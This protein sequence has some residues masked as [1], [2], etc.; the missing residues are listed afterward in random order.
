MGVLA[1]V[2]SAGEVTVSDAVHVDPESLS[3]DGLAGAYRLAALAR[4]GA[5]RVDRQT[6]PVPHELDPDPD[7]ARSKIDLPTISPVIIEVSE[8]VAS[9]LIAEVHH[10]NEAYCDRLREAVRLGRGLT[11]AE[12]ERAINTTLRRIESPFY[13]AEMTAAVA[14]RLLLPDVVAPGKEKSVGFFRNLPPDFLHSGAPEDCYVRLQT[15]LRFFIVHDKGLTNARAVEECGVITATRVFPAGLRS[16]TVRDLSSLEMIEIA[17]PGITFG[18]DPPVRPWLRQAGEKWQGH[19]GRLLT[20]WG[21]AWTVRHGMKVFDPT[22]GKL[23][24]PKIKLLGLA[25]AIHS[26]GM[27]GAVDTAETTKSYGDVIRVGCKVLAGRDVVGLGHDQVRPWQLTSQGMW[28]R[29]GTDGSRLID[30][31][32]TFL[33]DY[34][35]PKKHPGTR[36]DDG[37]LSPRGLA[38]VP[39]LQKEYDQVAVDCL[40]L[41]N[42]TVQEALQRVIPNAFGYHAHQIKPWETQRLHMWDEKELFRKAA[43][44]YAA[45]VGIGKL[46]PVSLKYELTQVAFDG[47]IS[48]GTR[49]GSVQELMATLRKNV[50]SGFEKC[51]SANMSTVFCLVFGVEALPHVTNNPKTKVS[52]SVSRHLADIG[53]T[54]RVVVELPKAGVVEAQNSAA[55]TAVRDD[56]WEPPKESARKSEGTTYD[57]LWERLR[58]SPPVA[59]EQRKINTRVLTLRISELRTELAGAILEDADAL[60]RAADLISSGTITS[61]KDSAPLRLAAGAAELPPTVL[62]TIKDLREGKPLKLRTINQA[63]VEV[64]RRLNPDRKIESFYLEVMR[65]KGAVPTPQLV[66]ARDKIQ[67]LRSAKEALFDNNLPLIMNILGGHKDAVAAADEMFTAIQYAIDTFDPSMGFEFSTRLVDTCKYL[68]KTP[69]QVGV[70]MNLDP[71]NARIVAKIREALVTQPDLTVAEVTERWKVG[72]TIAAALLKLSRTSRVELDRPHQEG[73]GGGPQVA[74]KGFS[75]VEEAEKREEQDGVRAAIAELRTVN[76][77]YAQIIE[78]RNGFTGAGALTLDQIGGLLGKTGE[79]IRQNEVKA[80]AAL[81]EILIRQGFAN[82]EEEG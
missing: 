57:I 65:E 23:D 59:K 12:L 27:Q 9:M 37:T 58:K 6:F 3:P 39:R 5:A 41:S 53:G 4:L 35:F 43:I 10:G 49:G 33:L 25:D 42:L 63:R 31:V 54:F 66:G 67:D 22:V 55:Q 75:P 69:A 71:D 74:E 46:D 8:A 7:T 34:E 13:G 48:S 45:E 56:D 19:T 52:S 80:V 15:V 60:I 11:T 62:R 17:A 30:E 72:A 14:A 82:E 29:V 20:M 24:L 77:V 28:Q 26:F 68:L 21:S 32:T 73:E 1:V 36:A 47:W 76:P 64:V 2:P 50:L 79:A 81:K 38:A 44:Y 70:P 61:D 78:L 51:A 40:R 16:T 18:F